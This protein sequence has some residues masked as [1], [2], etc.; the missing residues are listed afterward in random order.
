MGPRHSCG[1]SSET[2]PNIH[3]TAAEFGRRFSD[4]AA[5]EVIDLE[6]KDRIDEGV[7]A[8]NE[9]L[10]VSG[11]RWRISRANLP[12]VMSQSAPVVIIDG[13]VACTGE[14]PTADELASAIRDGLGY[15]AV[16]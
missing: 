7:A 9:A 15:V 5:I 8:L 16:R 13:K 14:I 3:D 4:L 1:G 6:T 2:K 12:L 11:E 10:E